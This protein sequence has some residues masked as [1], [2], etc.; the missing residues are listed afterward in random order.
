VNIKDNDGDVTGCK[1]AFDFPY[2]VIKISAKDVSPYGST[3]SFTDPA[4]G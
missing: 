4:T 1:I 3:V 2:P